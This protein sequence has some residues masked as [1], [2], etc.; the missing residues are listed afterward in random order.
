MFTDNRYRSALAT[1]KFLLVVLSATAKINE[2][3]VEE[4]DIHCV[5]IVPCLW[6]EQDNL[7]SSAD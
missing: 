5:K 6:S 4:V 1:T 7:V 3:V 2:V